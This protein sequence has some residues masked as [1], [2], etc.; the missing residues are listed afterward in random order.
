MPLSDD[1]SPRNF[2]TKISKY[3]KV[4]HLFSLLNNLGC[5]YSKFNDSFIRIIT[6]SD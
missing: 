6:N 5:R 2:I 1:L 3:E 4:F